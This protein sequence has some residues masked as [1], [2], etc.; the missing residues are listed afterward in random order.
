MKKAMKDGVVGQEEE[1]KGQNY[2]PDLTDMSVRKEENKRYP[3]AQKDKL[4]NENQ[5]VITVSIRQ[6]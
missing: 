5:E 2:R 3:R 1:Y 6:S 4:E